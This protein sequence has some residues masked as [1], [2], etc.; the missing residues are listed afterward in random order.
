MI[1]PENLLHGAMSGVTRTQPLL[2]EPLN[3]FDY[4]DGIVHDDADG[5]DES[6]ERQG[7][8]GVPQ[9]VEPGKRTDD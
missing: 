5:K 1:G 8:D 4:D 2:D 6:K 9:N 7:I 3:V